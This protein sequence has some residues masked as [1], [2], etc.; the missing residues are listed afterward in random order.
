MCFAKAPVREGPLHPEAGSASL[1]ELRAIRFER[2]VRERCLQARRPCLTQRPA[3]SLLLR[4][5]FASRA[6]REALGVAVQTS[7]KPA[8]PSRGPPPPASGPGD[9]SALNC[10]LLPQ[11]SGRLDPLAASGGEDAA[12]ADE[13]DEG[14]LRPRP[15]RSGQDTTKTVELVRILYETT[16]RSGLEIPGEVGRRIRAAYRSRVAQ[17]ADAVGQMIMPQRT[18]SA[19][20]SLPYADDYC[21]GSVLP[22][23]ITR[24]RGEP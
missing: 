12:R 15:R 23:A 3:R 24:A 21:P 8:A 1:R 22:E 19:R 16:R 14:S 17:E 5:D 2:F 7:S 11:L 4:D 18:F 6:E 13:A 10:C 9:L 20:A